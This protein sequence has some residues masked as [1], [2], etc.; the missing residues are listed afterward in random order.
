MKGWAKVFASRNQIYTELVKNEIASNEI[1]AVILNKQDSSY[2]FG[3][4]EVY[5]LVEN[6]EIARVIVDIFTKHE[7]EEKAE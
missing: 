3:F 1:G 4:F 6:A 7:S 5:V 2:L